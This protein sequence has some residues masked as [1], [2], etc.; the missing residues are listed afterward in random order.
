MAATIYQLPSL[1]PINFS[2]TAGTSIPSPPD[3]PD[4]CSPT[5]GGGPLSSHPT[6]PLGSEL[7]F[8][9]SSPNH[10][11]LDLPSSAFET[12]PA[13]GSTP[14][15]GAALASPL[16]PTSNPLSPTTTVH[17]SITAGGSRR[18][19]RKFLGL[20][21]FS[22]SAASSANAAGWPR[23][24]SAGM[25]GKRPSSPSVASSRMPS[26]RKRKSAG[27][28]RRSSSYFGS[29]AGD[30]SKENVNAGSAQ[31]N[32]DDEAGLKQMGPPPPTLPELAETLDG[33]SLG[34]DM[35]QRI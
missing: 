26:L 25:L 17:T 33:G 29:K 4:A 34:S 1:A 24:E 18:S 30:E 9:A 23:P 22:A 31:V 27:W 12:L 11:A 13:A 7:D 2:L 8:G 21:S 28:F 10:F 3:T 15:D 19:V 16:S 5:P 32:L 14:A 6:T 35:F 20:R